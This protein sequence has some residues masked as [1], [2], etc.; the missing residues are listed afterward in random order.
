MKYD[1]DSY[2]LYESTPQSVL[3]IRFK[4]T[5]KEL[6]NPDILNEAAQKAF[7]RFP[8]FARTL[9]IDESGGH[10]L[11]P[12]NSPI[13]V[14]EDRE[15]ITLGSEET[16]HLFFCITWC[17][18]AIYFNCAHTFCGG[19]GAMFWIKSTLWQYLTDLYHCEI[20][21]DGILTPDSPML[22]GET[23][24]PDMTTQPDSVP[25]PVPTIDNSYFPVEDY[26]ESMK[27]PT[28]D[29]VFTPVIIEKDELMKYARLNDG[30]PNSIL[31]SILF[32]AICKVL[33][34]RNDLQQISSKIACNYR[35]DVGCPDTYKDMVRL[36]HV[37]YSVD[38]ADWSI[39]KLSTVTR[40]SM[41][42][43]MQPELSWQEYQ[44]LM[45]LR[46]AIDAQQ[47]HAEKKKYALEHSLL[48]NGSKSTFV[49]SYAGNEQWGG[50]GDYIDSVFTLTAGHLMFEVNALPGKFC[51][52]FQQVI[53]D[54][55]YLKAFLSILD[56]EHIH[57]T[58]G[59]MEEKKLPRDPEYL[60]G[61]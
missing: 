9:R 7:R 5:L 56:E 26:M 46:D 36:L 24:L 13:V 60:S 49:I 21:S 37:K 44:N 29:H 16:N 35:K 22:P 33:K 12:S 41:Y 52:S 19:C 43:Q 38:M 10:V 3:N 31:S 54:D 28:Q 47:S 18:N 17:D 14:K 34:G 61:S 59:E 30:S 27:H 2:F 15:R 45:K 39:E 58:V 1:F 42:L 50:L 40:A 20:L 57:Y 11:I 32:K 23:A 55:R 6:I 8:Y 53:T 4:V 48:R 25:L 51:I